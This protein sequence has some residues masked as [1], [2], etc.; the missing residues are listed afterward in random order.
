MMSSFGHFF[1][2]IIISALAMRTSSRTIDSAELVN[3]IETPAIVAYNYPSVVRNFLIHS[4]HAGIVF[5]VSFL[6]FFSPA[7]VE[8]QIGPMQR[9]LDDSNDG[10]RICQIEY[11]V[12]KKMP[13]NCFKL[14]RG[15]TGCVSGDY[16]NPFHP[17]CF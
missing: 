16:M 14:S 17:D 2:L 11:Q 8:I 12:T 4:T 9:D 6:V 15:V 3:R 1:V 13:G 7:F 5:T 10:S